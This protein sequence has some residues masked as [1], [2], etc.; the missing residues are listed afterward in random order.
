MKQAKNTEKTNTKISKNS[1]P[2]H[3]RTVNA[4]AF[5]DSWEGRSWSKPKLEEARLGIPLTMELLNSPDDEFPVMADSMEYGR[6]FRVDDGKVYTVR[7]GIRS[8]A[9]GIGAIPGNSAATIF[10]PTVPARDIQIT[11]T[12]AFPEMFPVIFADAVRL[13]SETEFSLEYV[14]GS[15]QLECNSIISTKALPLDDTTL[16]QVGDDIVIGHTNLNSLL[17]AHC[18]YNYDFISVQVKVVSGAK[19]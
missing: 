7:L 16:E 18:T 13:Y 12:F 1:I 14:Y 17:P 3:E 10:I 2:A 9:E 11:A 15:A 8:D 6:R 4:G 19:S 5:E